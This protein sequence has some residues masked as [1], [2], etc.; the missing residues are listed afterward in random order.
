MESTD[1]MYMYIIYWH[2][3]LVI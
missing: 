1:R 3:L 2:N